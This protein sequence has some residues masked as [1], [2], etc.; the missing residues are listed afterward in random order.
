M[1]IL[2]NG[3][4][5]LSTASLVM[6]T[7]LLTH[8]TIA[9][10][11]IFL[12]RHQS[13]KALTL[14]PLVSHFF[15]FWLWLTTGMVTREWV[16]IHRKHHAKCETEDDPHSPQVRG[17]KKVLLEG[18]ELYQAES[19][20]QETLDKY[21][22]GTP[23]DWLE[24]H[25]Y[26]KHPA[27]GIALM[28]LIDVALF[29]VIGI[30]VFA[31]QMVWIPLMAA[32]VINGIGHFW[33]YRNFEITDASTN[34][35]P[36][37]I[38]IGGEELHNNHHAHSKSARL[39]SKPW[40]FDIGWLYIRL[41]E[42]LRLA[43]VM[44]VAPEVLS[45]TDKL[46]ID[47][48][49]LRAVIRH[50]GYI[51]KL[52]G[53]KVIKPILRLERRAASK[54]SRRLYRR[55]GKFMIREHLKMDFN[56]RDLLERALQQSQALKTVYQSKQKLKELWQHSSTNQT[57]RVEKLQQWCEEAKAS[58]IQVLQEF[59]VELQGYSLKPA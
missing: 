41:L 48:D 1:E 7:L 46:S 45:V 2:L 38:L 52:Y 29:G 17:L 13:H 6:A 9:S 8:I 20:N 31:V 25:L 58:G 11:T 59:A 23:D 27:L 36:W 16:A 40:E 26:A 24:H 21:G 50:R 51:I 14:H 5:D 47:M 56:A 12:H 22:H 34:I 28:L 35:L 3:L 43:R 32:G 49:T 19:A 15:R 53:Q 54:E 18:A 10:V 55:V 39:S 37:G 30:T 42:K 33:G 44:N 57:M 4:L